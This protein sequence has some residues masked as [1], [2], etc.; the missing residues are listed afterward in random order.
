MTTIQAWAGFSQ[1]SPGASTIWLQQLRAIGE[2]TMYR[3]LEQVPLNRLSKIG[4]DFTLRLLVENR[5]R[6][7]NGERT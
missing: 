2:D 3:L 6:L 1:F 5:E 7:V 4:R